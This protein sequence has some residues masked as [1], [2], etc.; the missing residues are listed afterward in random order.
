MAN[1]VDGPPTDSEKKKDGGV[2]DSLY[3]CIHVPALRITLDPH[4]AFSPA[5]S[6][7]CFTYCSQSHRGRTTHQEPRC[8][9]F[10]LRHVFPFELRRIR[11]ISPSFDRNLPHTHPANAGK[12]LP[13]DSPVPLSPEHRSVL[14][15]KHPPSDHHWS[16]GYYLWLSRSRPATAEH[17]LHMRHTIHTQHSYESAKQRWARAV[18]DGT[19]S[20]FDWKATDANIYNQARKQEHKDNL[21]IDPQDSMLLSLSTP[22]PLFEGTFEKYLGPGQRAL[23]RIRDLTIAGD[24]ARIAHSMF[25]LT[26]Q[27]APLDL[28]AR[29]GKTMWR[30]VTGK[31][32]VDD[33]DDDGKDEG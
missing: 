7:R 29:L 3:S 1:D 32:G 14:D 26:V 10:C 4:N 5:I 2:L 25:D 30:I 12:W 6:E 13:I 28:G 22:P 23:V 11:I 15:P 24:Q 33:D 17:L 16:S 31:L 20:A 19:E 8:R 9:T 27:G 21:S 18:R